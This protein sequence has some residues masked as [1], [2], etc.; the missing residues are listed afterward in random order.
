MFPRTA[1]HGNVDADYDHKRKMATRRRLRSIAWRRKLIVFAKKIS[2]LSPSKTT[3]SSLRDPRVRRC[4][5]VLFDAGI[6]L[7]DEREVRHC[8]H[9]DHD[10]RGW[11]KFESTIFMMTQKQVYNAII[12]KDLLEVTAATGFFQ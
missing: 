6:A 12:P 2:R 3:N 8:Q 5:I 11:P 1:I 10:E 4:F 9:V 7:F